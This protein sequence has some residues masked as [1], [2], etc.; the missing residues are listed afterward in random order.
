MIGLQTELKIAN[1][2]K[3]IAEGEKQIEVTRQVLAEQREFEPYTAFK[4]IDRF[5]NGYVTIM[6]VLEFL[7]QNEIPVLEADVKNLFKMYDSNND[8]KLSY[9][10]FLNLALPR[11]SPSLRQL[12]T[13]RESYFVAKNDPLPYECEWALARVFDKEVNFTRK[14]EL[15]KDDLQLRY[16]YSPL[17][18]F[19]LIDEERLGYLD[20]DSLYIFLKRNKI[21][22]SESDILSLLR[23]TDK[24]GDGKLSYAE[25]VEAMSPIGQ[26]PLTSSNLK[27]SASH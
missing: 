6:D 11:T 4:R 8:G 27:R 14:N 10:D 25:F 2:L 23:R 24:D 12:C 20:L 18:A 7:R 17:E 21:M 16:D 1:I 9:T 22:T 15:L 19:R 5:G 3:N 13:T 26:Q